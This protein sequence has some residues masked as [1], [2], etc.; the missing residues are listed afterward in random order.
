LR[1]NP[2]ARE[3]KTKKFIGQNVIACES[4]ITAI[5]DNKKTKEEQKN[6]Y[7]FSRKR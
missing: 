4:D 7:S 5:L 3:S 1:K 2:Q 6:D